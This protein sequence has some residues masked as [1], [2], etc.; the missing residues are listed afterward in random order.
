ME[1]RG[2]NLVKMEGTPLSDA[3]HAQP[4]YP[5]YLVTHV[6][7]LFHNEMVYMISSISL[8]TSLQVVTFHR[9]NNIYIGC[10]KPFNLGY[11]AKSVLG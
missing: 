1:G 2:L 11:V 4:I 10:I 5:Y 3:S 6:E 7:Q 9:N 8:I